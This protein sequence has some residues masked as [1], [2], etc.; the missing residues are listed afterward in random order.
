MS[1]PSAR[2][3]TARSLAEAFKFR[4]TATSLSMP[5]H[6]DLRCM[7]LMC[8]KMGGACA[9]RLALSLERMAALECV[10]IS[11]NN[12]TVLP[13]SLATLPKLKRLNVSGN[14]LQA[15]P[16]DLTKVATL[17][18]LDASDNP[19]GEFP[20]AWIASWPR[21]VTLDLR[22]TRLDAAAVQ[23]LRQ[24]TAGRGTELRV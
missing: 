11:G 13:D 1:L 18:H 6:P 17:E 23:G 9:C 10:D 22:N 15:L 14:A 3:A 21:L 19:L 24:A 8:E 20:A 5:S 2:Q 16:V 7:N 4:A 12:F